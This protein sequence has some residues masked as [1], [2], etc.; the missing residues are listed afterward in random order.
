M[1][2]LSTSVY[3]NRYYKSGLYTDPTRHG[4]GVM[5]ST[6]RYTYKDSYGTPFK[7]TWWMMAGNVFE[8]SNNCN[9]PSRR[10]I[11][12]YL[13][14][15][16]HNEA[17]EKWDD[18]LTLHYHTY[19]WSD[20]QGDGI[21]SWEMAEKFVINQD[22]YEKTLCSFLIEDNIFPISF[23]SG[24]MYMDED[25]QDYQERFI[26]FDMS[27][28][29]STLSDGSVPFHP[30]AEN[31]REEGSMKQW[32]VRSVCYTIDN[33]LRSGLE[34]VFRE[35]GNGKDQMLCLWSHLPES[36]F[37]DCIDSLDRISHELSQQYDVEFM[38]CKDNEALRLWLAP[39]DTI[40]PSLHINEIAS[41]K[42]LRFRISTDGPVFQEAEPFVAVKYVNETY[43]RLDCIVN[44]ENQWETIKDLNENEIAKI[45]VTVCDSVANQTIRS[46]S[47]VPDDMYIDDKDAEY[48]EVEGDWSQ[49]QQECELWNLD[50][51]ILNDTGRVLLR[52]IISETRE[53]ALYFHSPG[54]YSNSARI[55]VNTDTLNYTEV[56]AGRDKW[57]FA[58]FHELKSGDLNTI[59]LENLSP[60]TKMGYD[61]L[62]ISPLI[63]DKHFKANRE[64]IAFG[65]VSVRDTAIQNIKL[66]NYGKE[67]VNITHCNIFGSKISL[68]IQAPFVLGSMQTVDLELKYS[69]ESFCEYND[70][71]TIKTNDPKNSLLYIPVFAS[72][73][74]YYQIVDNE[75]SNAYFESGSWSTS[76]A[77]AWGETSRYT[78]AG[79]THKYA[80]FNIELNYSGT[81]KLD[82]LIPS[83]SNAYTNANYII[84]VDGTAIDTVIRDQNSTSTEWKEIGE[85]DLPKN[86]SITV[87]VQDNGGG[88]GIVLRA[89]AIKFTL[90]EEKLL[91]SIN[92]SDIPEEFKLYQNYPNPF[93]PSTNVYFALPEEGLI[94]INFYDLQG[95]KIDHTIERELQAGY[96]KVKWSPK[97]LA[98]GMYLYKL[99]TPSGIAMNKCTFIK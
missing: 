28:C 14:N 76:S 41:P 57:Q 63:A 29:W 1:E 2:G 72:S 75:D 88:S 60:G 87:R 47:Y 10:N 81:Y 4:Y 67:D 6:F 3:D 98:S 39:H 82:Y 91:S 62:R 74:T 85:Y 68:N 45:S 48:Q 90:I 83:S 99:I 20:P 73:Y 5:D 49:Y 15:K 70:V 37:L 56:M 97:N 38:Y 21:F 53:Y 51:R 78:Y 23:R 9:I 32:R 34:S 69:S 50:A 65:D 13:M 31:Y 80:D 25:W 27:D 24:W 8:M 30:S 46:I 92:E 22:D 77:K 40:A 18:K 17:I 55:I 26:P 44:G 12:L 36:G 64:M 54:S 89:D 16:Y 11:T 58:G 43:E 66:S 19:N 61:V 79:N 96:H 86:T 93:N 95:R 84:I 7:M 71:L 42:G 35:A 52:P 33:A 94:K 59:I